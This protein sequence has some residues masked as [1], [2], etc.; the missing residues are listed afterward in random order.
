VDEGHE[1][2][3]DPAHIQRVAELMKRCGLLGVSSNAG[4]M[5]H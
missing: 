3:V 2:I 5:A 4:I 1:H